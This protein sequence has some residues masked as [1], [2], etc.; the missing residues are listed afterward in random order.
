MMEYYRADGVRITHDPFAPEMSEKYGVPGE[1]DSEGFDPY[2]DSVGPG[3]YGGII[4]RDEHGHAIMGEQYQNHNPRP[5][6]VY[7]GGGYTPVNK[8][9]EDSDKLRNLL[10][11]Y[12]DLVNDISTGGAQPLHMC[13]MSQRNQGSVQTLVDSGADIE[14]L[15]TY[16]YTPLLRMASNNLGAGAK[17]LL[18]AGVDP[19][20]KGTGGHSP[21]QCAMMSRAV[22]VVRVLKEWG[23]QRKDVI[24]ERILVSGSGVS[25]VNGEYIKTDAEEIPHG[26]DSVCKEQDW[27]TDSMWKKLNSGKSWYKASNNAYIYW[28][29]SDGCW[30][31]D[32]PNGSGAYKAKAPMWAP[33][34]NGWKTLCGNIKVPSLVAIFRKLVK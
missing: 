34:Q 10:A 8:A 20:N 6:P 19:T 1:T 33:P 23:P 29:S 32:H 14:A 24:I 25:D 26:F 13:G 15:D 5:G 30:W 27:N 9:L 17:T 21:M 3:I 22:D 12:P 2:K 16:G 18:E 7:A 31:I 4:R 28:N 11:K